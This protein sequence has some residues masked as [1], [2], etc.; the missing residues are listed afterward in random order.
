MFTLKNNKYTRDVS[1]TA[2]NDYYNILTRI[3]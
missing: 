1:E 3:T 2:D